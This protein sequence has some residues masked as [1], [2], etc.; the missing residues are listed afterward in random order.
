MKQRSIESIPDAN[1]GQTCSPMAKN[2]HH[3]TD[4]IHPVP[5]QQPCPWSNEDIPVSNSFVSRPALSEPSK[6]P[7]KLLVHLP[8]QAIQVKP[9]PSI[10][11]HISNHVFKNRTRNRFSISH[12]TEPPT[13]F[14]LSNQTTFR[15]IGSGKWTSGWVFARGGRFE[16][17]SIVRFEGFS[18]Q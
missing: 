13:R 10:F 3:P 15:R 7:V 6:P 11:T 2:S 14:D 17:C 18:P 1:R 5:S 8:R 12:A 9:D 4:D 16:T